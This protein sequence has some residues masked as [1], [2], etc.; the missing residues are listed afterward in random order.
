MQAKGAII[1]FGP[2]SG[3]YQVLVCSLLIL[4]VIIYE[5]HRPHTGTQLRRLIVFDE[6]QAQLFSITRQCLGLILA[7]F[8]FFEI[9]TTAG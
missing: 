4:W 3:L 6:A 5:I 2:L 8:G 1:E 9:F 7:V